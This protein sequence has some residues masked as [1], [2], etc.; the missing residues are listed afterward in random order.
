[1][2]YYKNLSPNMTYGQAIYSETARRKGIDNTPTLRQL[3]V[4]EYLAT[5]L[6]EPLCEHFGVRIFNSSFFRSILLNKEVGGVYGSDHTVIE[7]TAAIDYD[8]DHMELETGVTNRD[9]FFF[10]Y[11]NLD[12]YKLIWEFGNKRKPAWVHV[13]FSTDPKKNAKRQTIVATRRTGRTTYEPF[14]DLR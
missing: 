11:D 1:M 8:M 5:N 3:G 14:K 7:D 10:I 9:V 12:Y 13:S 2:G 4:M 6:H